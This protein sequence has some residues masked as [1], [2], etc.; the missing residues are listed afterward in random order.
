MNNFSP[1][2]VINHGCVLSVPVTKPVGTS[3]SVAYELGYCFQ[4]DETHCVLIASMD[5]QGG[6]DLCVGNDAFVF[7]ALK[8]IQPERAIPVNRVE[9]EF[10]CRNEIDRAFLAKFPAT[11]GFIPLET[12]LVDGTPH[13]GA[14]TGFLI[15]NC[16]TFDKNKESAKSKPES[17]VEI[18]QMRWDGI[19]MEF[20]NHTYARE[21]LGRTLSGDITIA[22]FCGHD[23]GFLVALGVVGNGILVFKFDFLEGEWRSVDCGN[24][25]CNSTGEEREPLPGEPWEKIPGEIEPSIR[26][27]NGK[28]YLYTRGLDSF[29]RLYES[30]DGLNYQF[31]LK[32]HNITVPQVLNQG[33]DGSLYIATNPGPG[34]LR[35]PLNAYR[36][37]EEP[38]SVAL[39]LH[40][41]DGVRDDNGDSIPFVDHAIGVNIY[42]EGKRRHLAF[43]RVCDLKERTLHKYQIDLGQDL[44]LYGDVGRRPRLA[45]TGLYAYELEFE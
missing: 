11:G 35:N 37:F 21:I 39:V 1:T 9:E 12:K 27:T 18:I 2:K 10:L 30:L 14:G 28:Y 32:R 6:G 16:V 38:S 25:F 43:Y 44:A 19:T 29:G 33:L 26:E 34:W 36:L 23:R 7:G 3:Q 45:F 22:P 24:E 42:L 17:F 8:E 13:P 15:S 31:I 5:E 40:D 41:Q 4:I 20:F